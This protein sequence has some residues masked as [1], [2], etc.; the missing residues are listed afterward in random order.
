MRNKWIFTLLVAI[1]ALPIFSGAVLAEEAVVYEDGEYGVIAKAINA[2][3]GEKSGAAGFLKEEAALTIKDGKATLTITVPHN[4]M[5]E[6]TGLQVE[7]KEPAVTEGD[8]ADYLAFSL[9]ELKKELNAQVQ[10]EVPS[11]GLVHDVP[12]KFVLEGL[13]QIP[14][15][16]DATEPEEEPA[17]PE[18]P[19]EPS[20][21]EQPGDNDKQENVDSAL[22]PDEVYH[23][24]FISE[25]N[26]VN[27]QFN[28]PAALLYKDGEK[29]IQITGT[30]GQYI[31]SLTING[32][33]VTWGTK[34]SDG[35]FTIQFK[36]GDS[37]SAKLDFGMVINAGPTKMEHLVDLSFDES[38]KKAVET[39]DHTLLP[40]NNES[41][42]DNNGEDPAEGEEPSKGEKPTDKEDDANKPEDKKDPV[43]KDNGD[44]TKPEAPEK[45]NQ[46]VPDKAYEV[47][48]VIK[49]ETEDK[50]SAADSFFK[51]PALLLQ[52]DGEW[53]LQIT[54]TGK[55]FIDS[56]KNKFGEMVVVKENGDSIV[57]QFKLDGR[58]SDIILLDMIITVPGVYEGQH[59]KARLFLD[60]SSM[61][62]VKAS[63]YR[64]VASTNDNGP[65]G[66][67]AQNPE[68]KVTAPATPK[69]DNETPTKGGSDDKNSNLTPEKPKFGP[70]A[71]NNQSDGQKLAGGNKLNPQTG[72]NTDIMLYV[73][74]LIGS[75][76]PLAIKMKRRF[77]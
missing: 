42:E 34:N 3:T 74:L 63:N 33:E 19:I 61:K 56:L 8:D 25:S 15:V 66:E 23:I 45:K 60:E 54:V 37:L 76:I 17:K 70:G 67:N 32:T 75:A 44:K 39:N 16:E 2:E 49:H 48:F 59:H 50:P 72:E 11:I 55:Q 13:D 24:N 73:L 57:Y 28:N 47:D 31:E 36:V 5:A 9:I 38:T 18:E 14:V 53:Y 21:P 68:D 35:T 7:G 43:D 29:Y 71:D 1:L 6:I 52:K 27:R 4:E 40:V 77:V 46:L 30:G 65:D 10:Y 41:E 20:E 58:I 62:E 51:G 26:A 64:L 22:I 12:F 69:K